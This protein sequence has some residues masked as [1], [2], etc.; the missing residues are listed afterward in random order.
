MTTDTQAPGLP[1]T[2]PRK[3]SAVRELP[4]LVVLAVVLALFIKAFLLQAFSI[5]SGSMQH[6]LEVGDRVLVNKLVYQVRG[7]HR[8]EVVVFNGIDDWAP[9]SDISPPKDTFHKVLRA[10]GNAVGVTSAGEKDYIKRVIGLPGDRVMCCSDTGHVVVTPKGGSPVELS[11]P[12]L[13]DAGNDQDATK[14]FCES[15]RS[16]ATC[17][18][19]A[20][21]ILVPKGRLWVM[22]DHRGASADSR[23]HLDDPHHGTIPI[24]RVVGR[25]FMVVYP[26]DR[27]R[28]CGCR[29][30]LPTPSAHL[31]RRSRP[32]SSGQ[33]RWPCCVA[34]ARC[35]APPDARA[36]TY[37][38]PIMTEPKAV[39]RTASRVL[40][41]DGAGRLLLFRGGDPSAPERGTWWF[42]PGGGLDPGETLLEGA[43]REL[44]EETGLHCDPL[45]L[46]EPVHAEESL[47][48]FAGMRITQQQTFFVLRVDAHEVD[49]TGFE[50][51][52][53]SSIVEH[54]WWERE[55]LRS[56][57]DVVYPLCLS[58]LLD[59]VA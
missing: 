43:V 11:E 44:F 51:L 6:T 59:R 15:G 28:C 48:D 25:A 41:L 35:V 56:T 10:V 26:V 24:D 5:P 38:G 52:E 32:A 31:L 42:T 58:E 33:C 4:F 18:A 8:G 22:G 16:R 2:R 37:A 39:A 1:A 34:G 45:A 36:A 29:R 23:A 9:E 54:R 49:T 3:R 55:A 47:F 50:E 20:P 27:G 53:A 14:W 12:Y 40:L 19:G 30:R 7:I 21:G 57:A 17:P 13:L 46:G